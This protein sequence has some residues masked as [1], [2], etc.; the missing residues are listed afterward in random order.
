MVTRRHAAPGLALPVDRSSFV[1][2]RPEVDR[3]RRL[4]EGAR[5]VTLVGT[6][7]VGKTRLVIRVATAVERSFPAGTVFAEL[8]TVREPALVASQVAQ[9][10]DV[11]DLSGGWLVGRLADVIA[12]RQLLL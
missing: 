8:S 5:L 9:A 1:G 10:L 11:Q 7:G 12:D 4:L 6:G 2:R 3:A